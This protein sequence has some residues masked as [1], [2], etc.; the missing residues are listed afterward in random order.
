MKNNR[1][2]Y[3]FLGTFLIGLSI[4]ITANCQPKQEEAKDI[5]NQ[6]ERIWKLQRERSENIKFL[7][8]IAKNDTERR[9]ELRVLSIIALGDMRAEEAVS[10]LITNI[11]IIRPIKIKE[12]SEEIIQPC[13]T[14]LIKIGKASSKL[15]LEELGKDMTDNRRLLL[16]QVIQKVE[17]YEVG[18]FIIEKAIKS[19]GSPKAKENLGKSLELIKK[20]K[21]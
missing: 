5:Q 2:T 4:V 3:C 13:R 7:L 1:K 6:A 21:D 17:G 10:L 11:D 20:L 12:V 16:T 9:N 18:T 8:D 15:A 19:A 14:A